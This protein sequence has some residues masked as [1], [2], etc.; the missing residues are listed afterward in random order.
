MT[1]PEG[2]ARPPNALP[3]RDR[4]GGGGAGVVTMFACRT[5][6]DVLLVWWL[7]YRIKPAIEAR[8]KGFLGVRLYIDWRRR[9]VRSVSLWTD[10]ASLYDMGE[11]RQHVG[12]TRIPRRRGIQTSCGVYSYEGDCSAV[13]FGVPP[14]RKPNPLTNAHPSPS[15]QPG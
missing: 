12:A 6:W 14:N 3:L 1:P 8:A 4:A 7:H 9:I 10:P 2:P 5:R 13:M 11:V 15:D